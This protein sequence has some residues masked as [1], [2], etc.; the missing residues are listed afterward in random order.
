MFIISCNKNSLDYRIFA[1]VMSK[2]E[3]EL[4]RSNVFLKENN[5]ASFE[6]AIDEI[7]ILLKQLESLSSIA[8]R[9]YEINLWVKDIIK[10]VYDY[11]IK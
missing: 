3:K 2:K 6:F 7:S 5:N 10:E 8:K 9:P 1:N 11:Q 4:K